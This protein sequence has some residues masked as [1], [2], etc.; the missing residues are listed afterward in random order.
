MLA[1]W[2]NTS[3]F[4]DA[5]KRWVLLFSKSQVVL[6]VIRRHDYS[7]QASVSFKFGMTKPEVFPGSHAQAASQ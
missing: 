7:G 4:S 5:V 3:G 2:Q 1:D 6:R